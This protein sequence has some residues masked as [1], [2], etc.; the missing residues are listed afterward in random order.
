[1]FTM[2]LRANKCAVKIVLFLPRLKAHHSGIAS[3]VIA[4][5]TIYSQSSY[6]STLC[7]N[8]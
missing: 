3:G 1:M 8:K 2:V 7:L 4:V 6:E 5:I